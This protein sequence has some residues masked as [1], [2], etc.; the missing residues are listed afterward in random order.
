MLTTAES[1]GSM[2]VEEKKMRTEQALRTTKI[3]A[4]L[5]VPCLVGGG[6]HPTGL[7]C[8]EQLALYSVGSSILVLFLLV[9]SIGLYYYFHFKCELKK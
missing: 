6:E 8:E 4:V 3:V 2:S 9:G 7:D 1:R 5:G